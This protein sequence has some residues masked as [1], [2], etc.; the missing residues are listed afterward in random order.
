MFLA[1]KVA[2]RII[3]N[4]KD[5]VNFMQRGT[6][7]CV[8]AALSAVLLL[9]ACT[10]V[11]M[12]TLESAGSRADQ[13]ENV[14]LTVMIDETTVLYYRDMVEELRQE[15]SEY[16][17]HSI[18]WSLP[19][20]EKTVKTAMARKESIEVVKWFPNQMENFI[21]SSAAMDLTPYMDG[22][23][24]NI[25]EDGAL[26]IGTYDGKVYCLPSV[27][28]Y[29][30][31]EVNEEILERA[32]VT[33]REAWTWEEFVEACGRIKSRTDVYPF[34]IRDS[35]VCWFMRNALLQI[36][37]D[38]EEMKR[39]QSGELSF[40]DSRIAEAFDRVTSL[41]RQDYAYPGQRAF[42]Q[43]NEQ[44]DA[45]FERGEI[46]MMFNVNNSV[47]ESLERM[48]AAGRGRIRVISFPT[49]ASADCDY[50]LGGCEGFFIPSNTDHPDEAIRLLKFLT[51]SR[52][53]TELKNQGFAVPVNLGEEEKKITSDSGK[54]FSQELMNLSSRL[55]NYI[56]YELPAAYYMDKEN[57]LKELET[58]RLEA[59]SVR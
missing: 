24:K 5:S 15:F 35:R 27:V 13:T 56:N 12:G 4:E 18:E 54:V 53:F 45:A 51:S 57:T 31:L 32:G 39:F 44:I 52:I 21:S 19:E 28:V 14:D 17:I 1:A 11:E 55:Y 33:V 34:G 23:W 8:M 9:T 59:V 47:K 43:T 29:P 40:Y 10:G 25:W 37:D 48:E 7:V 16:G 58:M 30:V 49:M 41:F 22:E 20:V 6:K 42:S 36:W 50:L 46:A 38:A 2:D 3:K 26:D